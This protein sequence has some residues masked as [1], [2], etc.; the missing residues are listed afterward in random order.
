MIGEKFELTK[1]H[2]TLLRN[3]YFEYDEYTETG[4]PVADCKRPYGNSDV[5]VD[6]YEILY[7]KT[8]DLY[9]EETDDYKE[10][11]EEI[12]DELMRLHYGTAT[13]L[14]I[15]LS[16]KSFEPG[17]YECERTEERLGFSWKKVG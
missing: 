4:A 6:I 8:F 5:A 2:I 10:E 14:Q 3:M 15:I 7:G 11:W 17:I 16:T 1:N 9:D 13:A 12:R